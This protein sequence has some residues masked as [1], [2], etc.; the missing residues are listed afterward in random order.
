MARKLKQEKLGEILERDGIISHEQLAEA[1]ELQRESG[2]LIGEALVEMEFATEEDIA[3][4]LVNQLGC[5]F[6]Q[7]SQY[8]YDSNNDLLGLFSEDMLRENAFIP[9]DQIGNTV[10]VISAGPLSPEIENKIIN[11]TGCDV[12]VYISTP[13]DIREAIDEYLFKK[14]ENK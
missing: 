13:T 7:C 3:I 8:D 11:L 4:S 10:I 5:P 1:L 2:C 14:E 6:M 9:V 12:S